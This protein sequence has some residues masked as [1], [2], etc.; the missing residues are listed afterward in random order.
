MVYEKQDISLNFQSDLVNMPTEDMWVAMREA[1]PGWAIGREDSSVNRLEE[2]A[3]CMMGKESALF[4]PTGRMATLVGLMTLCGRGNQVIL[5]E[6]SHIVWSQEWGVSYICG[7]YPRLIKGKMGA[8]EP[9]DVEAAIEESR[10]KHRPT[11]DVVCLENT[12][13]MAGGT[14]LSLE[15]TNSLCDVA[16][17][18]DARVLLDGARIFYAAIALK[19]E[20]AKLVK[21]CDIVTFN[22]TKGL[23]APA[24]ALICGDKQV[25]EEA[26]HSLGRIGGNSFHKAGILA[27]AG[28]IA[29]ETM[30][31][32]LAEDQ[33]RA[34]QFAQQLSQISG[35]KVDMKAVQTNIVMADISGTRLNSDEFLKLNNELGMRASKLTSKT[36]RFAFHR[37]I[38]DASVEQALDIIR[39]IINRK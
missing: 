39:Q 30:V 11:T 20:P 29:L 25:I 28:I 9:A 37:H 23:S 38:T 7:A 1:K 24:G 34:K 12:H 2:V 15:Q 19:L 4:V 35:I 5:E 17:K 13:N 16:H 27:A 31:D 21:N 10:F 18:H 32:R 14:V 36:I 33:V 3:S 22:L 26:Y 6:E 8:M